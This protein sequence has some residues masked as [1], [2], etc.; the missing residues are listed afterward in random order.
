MN[1]TIITMFFGIYIMVA[2]YCIRSAILSSN[3]IAVYKVLRDSAVFTSATIEDYS[4][5]SVGTNPYNYVHY[6]FSID[7]KTKQIEIIN[8]QEIGWKHYRNL[9][10]NKVQ[11]VEIMFLPYRSDINRL[12]G[13]DIDYAQRD[14]HFIITWVGFFWIPPM[15]VLWILLTAINIKRL[16]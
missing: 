1:D 16:S 11:S 13:K 7:E 12:A 3:E 10:K 8:K 14:Y 5:D 9:M 6:R 2:I 4:Q 15:I